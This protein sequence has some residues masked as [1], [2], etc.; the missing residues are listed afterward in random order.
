MEV[1][2]TTSSI[3]NTLELDCQLKVVVAKILTRLLSIS[4]RARIGLNWMRIFVQLTHK[5]TDSFTSSW[6]KAR[7]VSVSLESENAS[8]LHAFLVQRRSERGSFVYI[9]SKSLDESMNMNG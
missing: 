4:L 7:A 6:T 5:C 9:A 3:S 8:F 1:E 2:D